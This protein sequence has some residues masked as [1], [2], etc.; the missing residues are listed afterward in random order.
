MQWAIVTPTP[1]SSGVGGGVV[2]MAG[3]ADASTGAG[4]STDAGATD[5]LELHPPM[6]AI[7]PTTR[8]IN[9]GDGCRCAAQWSFGVVVAKWPR[10]GGC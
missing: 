1:R 5:E 9:N 7:A 10:F 8:Q 3:V 2:S 6:T 4:A